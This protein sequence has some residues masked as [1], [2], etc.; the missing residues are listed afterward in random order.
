[1]DNFTLNSGSET[2]KSQNGS[3][4]TPQPKNTNPN[5]YIEQVL[6]FKSLKPTNKMK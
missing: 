3:S 4:R 1:M 6:E 5:P 2:Q